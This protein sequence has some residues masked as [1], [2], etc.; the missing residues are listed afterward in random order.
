MG[1]KKRKPSRIDVHPG[2][3]PRANSR[4]SGG[5]IYHRTIRQQLEI[6]DLDHP[7]HLRTCWRCNGLH[8]GN[9]QKPDPISAGEET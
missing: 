2:P 3:F 8:E 1:L 7:L 6:L 5:R 9:I 4:S